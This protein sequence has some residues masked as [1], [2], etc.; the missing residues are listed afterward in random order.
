[1]RGLFPEEAPAAASGYSPGIGAEGRRVVFVSGQKPKDLGADRETKNR[2]TLD[3]IGL[4]LK[5]ASATYADKVMIRA[6]FVH[7]SRDLA[8][9]REVRLEDLRE[10]YPASTAVGVTELAVP[11]LEIKIEVVAIV[12]GRSIRARGP[13]AGGGRGAGRGVGPDSPPGYSCTCFT[14]LSTVAA[15]RSSTSPAQR[16]AG[17]PYS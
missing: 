12:R 3:R 17:R 15:I 11:G 8:A 9:D 7:L 16:K 2:Q 5:A 1:M 14:S 10:P 6:Y 13:S 4:V